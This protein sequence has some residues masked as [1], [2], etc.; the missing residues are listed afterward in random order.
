M[1][2]QIVIYVHLN[3]IKLKLS[4]FEVG[5]VKF[6][7]YLPM[8]GSNKMIEESLKLAY[9]EDSEFIKEIGRAHV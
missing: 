2:V 6:R 4:N 3:E 1:S 9:G 5:F 8:G 7:E